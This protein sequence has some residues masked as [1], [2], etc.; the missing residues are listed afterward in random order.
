MEQAPSRPVAG[1]HTQSP[2]AHRRK[3]FGPSC[4]CGESEARLA[5]EHAAGWASLG[6][7]REME[8]GVYV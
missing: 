5:F 8:T 4:G 7:A 3:L 1:T 6:D 2:G